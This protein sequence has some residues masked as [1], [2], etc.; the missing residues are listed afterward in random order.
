MAEANEQEKEKKK[1]KKGKESKKEKTNFVGEIS[2]PLAREL[3]TVTW[4]SYFST[5][6]I[7]KGIEKKSENEDAANFDDLYSLLCREDLIITAI[8]NLRGN[9][10]TAT[11]GVDE[12]TLDSMDRTNIQRI[13]DQLKKGEYKFKPIKRIM[14][15]KPGKK[16]K[17]PLGIP[18]FEDRIV[19]DMIRMVLEA[20]YEPIFTNRHQNSNYGFR[21]K[22]CCQNAIEVTQQKGQAMEWCIEGDIIGA[23]NRMV[24]KRLMKF[25]REKIKDERFLKLIEDGLKSGA[26]HEGNYEH[27]II[28]TPQGGIASP[29]LFNIYMSK[30]DEYVI[31]ELKN[32]I[33]KKNEEEQRKA[34]PGTPIYVKLDGNL[35]KV[36]NKIKKMSIEYGP[37]VSS[38]EPSVR[39]DYEDLIRLKK[40]IIKKR[41]TVPFLDK[42]RALIRVHYV[43]YADDW[44]LMTNA[45]LDYVLEIKEKIAKFLWDNLE[46]ELSPEKTKITN[47]KEE[48]VNFLGFS[49]TLGSKDRILKMGSGKMQ[50]TTGRKLTIGIDINRLNSRFEQK[51]FVINNKPHRKPAWTTLSDYEIIMRYNSIMRG[52]VNYYGE[53][54]RDF[55]QINKYIYFLYYSCLHTLCNKHKQSLKK[56]FIEY[57]TNEM[58]TIED[59]K[60]NRILKKI[61]VIHAKRQDKNKEGDIIERKVAL[62]DYQG[63]KKFK[64]D[65]SMKR[66][67]RKGE[68]I[69]ER[70]EDFMH[71]KINWKTV[72]K[73]NRYCVIC[74]S[75]KGVQMH[76]IRHVRKVGSQAEIGFKRVIDLLNRKQIMVCRCCHQRIHRGKYDGMNLNDLYDPDLATL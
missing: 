36:K 52:L 22:K 62:L 44:I 46:L 15:P 59:R 32:E 1:N 7:L 20:I 50:R 69:T 41:L 48:K 71:V 2:T 40:E 55:S 31:G 10:G 39:K 21:P 51:K 18:T 64:N 12:K 76:H 63:C 37:G 75:E 27:T 17:R 13:L 53:W 70:D 19:Q 67:K 43:R 56:T 24:H 54:I 47:L 33:K 8:N 38:W 30:L 73:L 49:M 29:I 57:G 26:I 72:Y 9:K 42:K 45:S 25:L 34:K 16:E 68:I 60:G 11:A 74:G 58:R 28:G 65:V 4:D 6:K 23:Y 3:G 66:L 5:R 14:I 35:R 61:R